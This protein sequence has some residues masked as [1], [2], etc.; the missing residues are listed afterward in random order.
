MMC[1]EAPKPNVVVICGPTATG[2][3]A[4]A[5]DLA[6]IF[7]AEIVG[8]DS[9]QV[10]RYMDIGTAKPTPEERAA[11]PHHMIDIVEPDA[12][13]DARQYAET[14][15]EKIAV[16]HAKGITPFVVGGTGFYI[17]ALL[18]GLFEDVPS[19]PDVRRRLRQAARDRGSAFLHRQLAQCDPD[20]AGRLH[21]NDSY[22]IVRALEVYALTGKPISAYHCEH[23]FSENPFNVL[24]IGLNMS[25]D[26]LYDRINRRVDS[27]IA[28]GFLDEVRGLLDMG[29]TEDLKSMQSI[30]YRHLIDFIHGRFPWEEMLRTLK[31]DTR[32]Y[33][34]R[35]LTW[36]GADA[37]VLWLNPERPKEIQRAVAGFLEPA[38]GNR[39]Q[40]IQ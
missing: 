6:E 1:S 27:M 23:G 14:A 18:Y 7:D 21:P 10:Y 25:R 30:G 19:N 24:K 36:F 35:Q 9:M 20:T 16:L 5:I 31:R 29:F 22:R 28:A 12:P 11:V 33:A 17:K 39:G 34:K 8:A 26:L 3:T 40:A 38:S 13:L 37:E 32:R 4:V 2:K 15:R